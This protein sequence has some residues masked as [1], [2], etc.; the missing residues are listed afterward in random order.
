MTN[1]PLIQLKTHILQLITEIA[2][3][4]RYDTKMHHMSFEITQLQAFINHLQ[5][6]IN[7]QAITD[8]EWVTTIRFYERLKVI[9]IEQ[10]DRVY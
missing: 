9:K 10:N 2:S 5:K 8:Y 3:Q 1:V 4:V 7:L 6:I